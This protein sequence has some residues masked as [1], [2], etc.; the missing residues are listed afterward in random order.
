MKRTL[1][2]ANLKMHFNTEEA[3]IYLHNLNKEVEAHRSVEVVLAPSLLSLQPLSVQVDHRKFRLACQN[4]YSRDEGAFTGEVSFTMMR[5][6]IDYAIIGHSERRIYFHESLDEI[7][8]KVSACVRNGIKPILCIGESK[9][10]KQAGEAK[11]VIHD[12]LTTALAD[13]T[14]EEI[15]DV[16]IAYE[17]VWAISTFNGEIAKPNDVQKTIDFIRYQIS[18]LYGSAASKEVRVIYGGDVNADIVSGYLALDG[19]DG[20]LVGHASLNYQEFSSIINKAYTVT[21]SKK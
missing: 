20:A 2:V 3:S 17:P 12:Q 14:S 11:R 18:E 6:L 19:C 8:D 9:P 4:G 16:V 5:G 10:D 13:L 7:R 1:I 15:K 21:N